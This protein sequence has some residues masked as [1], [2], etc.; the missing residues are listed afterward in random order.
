[1]SIS[2]LYKN[3]LEN[4]TSITESEFTPGWGTAFLYDNDLNSAFRGDVHYFTMTG[5]TTVLFNFGSAVYMDSVVCVN[6]MPYNGTMWLTGGTISSALDFTTGIPIDGLGTSHS[7][8][9]NQGYQYWKL[10]MHGQ[11]ANRTH[12]INEL[13]LGKR[14][15]ITE[16]PSYPFENNIEENSID[17]I[18]ERGQRW[19]YQNYV[20]KNAI[21]N[22][23]GVNATTESALFN[24]YKFVRKDTIPFWVCLNPDNSPLDINYVRFRDSAF[25]SDEITKN[26]FDI[27]IELE[28]EL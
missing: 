3:K 20:R 21:L 1:M 28:K 13:Y 22:F 10:W 12:Q 24:M 4:V 6:N 18:S 9:G 26:I 11:T 14:T 2:F 25:L 19:V 17:L 15:S 23:E 8:F 5:T 16:M 27:T 7:Y